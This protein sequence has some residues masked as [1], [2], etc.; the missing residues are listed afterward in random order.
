MAEYHIRRSDKEIIDQQ[1][2]LRLIKIGK[3]ISLALSKDDEP[4]I[5]TVSYGYSEIENAIYFHCST[6]GQKN[7]YISSNNK[8][9]GTIIED[10]G[11]NK[12]K[13]EHYFNSLIVKGIISEVQNIEDKKKGLDILMRHLEESPEPIK[14]RNIIDDES[15]KKVGIYRLSINEITGKH[16]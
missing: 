5:V 15:Y 1:E 3:Y 14:K 16:N 13:C 11:Y 4:Y 9:C 2:L 7:D 6:I 8:C 10:H 12:E